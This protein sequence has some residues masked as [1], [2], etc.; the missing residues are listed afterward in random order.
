[1]L[2]FFVILVAGGMTGLMLASVSLDL[3]VHDTYFVVAHLHYVLLGGAVFPLFGAIYY[4]FPKFTGRMLGEAL[5]RWHFW[6]FF[7]GFN[8]AFFPMHLLGCTAC[9][10]AYGAIRGPGLGRHEHACNRWG[11]RHRRKRGGVPRERGDG[12]AAVGA[13]PLTTHGARARWSGALPARRRRTTSTR[14][15]WCTAAS[16]SGCSPRSLRTWRV[17]RPMPARCW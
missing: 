9:P 8:V 11:I 3:Q 15:R 7:V 6:L 16:R 12:V 14:C 4:W 13:A 2:A 10:G 5:G 1:V 17:S